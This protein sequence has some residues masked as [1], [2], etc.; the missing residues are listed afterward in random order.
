MTLRAISTFVFKHA[1]NSAQAFLVIAHENILS[2]LIMLVKGNFTF[3]TELSILAFCC[4][5]ADNREHR[6]L[7]LPHTFVL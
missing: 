6:C 4:Y 2:L 5:A 3:K 1:S 7:L